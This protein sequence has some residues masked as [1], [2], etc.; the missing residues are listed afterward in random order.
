MGHDDNDRTGTTSSARRSDQWVPVSRQ[1]DTG[2][3]CGLG[4]HLGDI[5]YTT[6]QIC[7]GTVRADTLVL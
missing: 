1:G 2:V 3:G 4:E 6:Y 7:L 5:G